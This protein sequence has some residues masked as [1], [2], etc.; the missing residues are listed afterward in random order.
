MLRIND[1]YDNQG[2]KFRILSKISSGYIWIN[3]EPDAAL[4]EYIEHSLLI[5]L[6]EKGEC[7]LV[8]DPFKDLALIIEEPNAKNAI[9]RDG[10][11]QLIQPIITHTEFYNPSIRGSLITI[12][13][14]KH[15]TTKQTIYRLLRKYWQRGQTPN[16]LLPVPIPINVKMAKNDN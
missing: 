15:K 9:K 1:V 12:I 14:E 10:N 8:D 11:F 13:L 6:I 16:A 4:P 7:L 2:T 3:I 5:D